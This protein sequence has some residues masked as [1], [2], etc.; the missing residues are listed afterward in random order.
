MNLTIANDLP[1]NHD[2]GT[3]EA[4]DYTLRAVEWAVLEAPP[5]TIHYFSNLPYGWIP[6]NDLEFVQLFMAT[7]RDDWMAFCHEGRRY[8]GRLVSL[9]NPPNS[10]ITRQ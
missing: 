2:D 1:S 5:K 3:Y 8:L 9:P 10:Q 6:Q 7:W 4:E